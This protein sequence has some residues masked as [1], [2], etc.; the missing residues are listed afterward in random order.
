MFLPNF[1]LHLFK[2]QPE[3]GPTVG[4]KLVAAVIILYHP[5]KYKIVY[6]YIIYIVYYILEGVRTVCCLMLY[7][8]ATSLPLARVHEIV[9]HKQYLWIFVLKLV[10]RFR[11]G[12]SRALTWASSF[13][14]KVAYGREK[15]RWASSYPFHLTGSHRLDFQWNLVLENLAKIEK[16]LIS[17]K[18]GRYIG[19]FVRRTSTFYCC[20][21]HKIAIMTMLTTISNGATQMERIVGFPKQ[22][23][24]D[25]NTVS[26]YII[27]YVTT[28]NIVLCEVR[29]AYL[30]CRFSSVFQVLKQKWQQYYS[31]APHSH[32]VWS[33]GHFVHYVMHLLST[34]AQM[35]LTL[36]I[37]R[38]ASLCV[39]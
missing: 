25:N 13:L 10:T 3:D 21:R 4:P 1:T 28:V 9:W 7:G 34:S 29:T 15:R 6:D 32:L 24:C 19:Q 17:L 2:D 26:R 23:L 11:D 37:K 38:V 39:V 8:F 35:Y 33:V 22:R 30:Y 18:L 27:G 31:N 14:D 20:R 5:I 12:T 36:Y 16:I